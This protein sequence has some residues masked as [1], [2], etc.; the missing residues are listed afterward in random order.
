MYNKVVDGRIEQ[1]IG[2]EW[3][4]MVVAVSA[5]KEI[6]DEFRHLV[7]DFSTIRRPIYFLELDFQPSERRQWFHSF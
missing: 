2:R 1:R 4:N 5:I 7:L 3:S 6:R